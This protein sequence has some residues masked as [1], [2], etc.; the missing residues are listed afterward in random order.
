[1]LD[2]IIV[3]LCGILF[4]PILKV[5]SPFIII[6]LKKWTKESEKKEKQSES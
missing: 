4:L 3:F 2:Y 5:M 1:M 6:A